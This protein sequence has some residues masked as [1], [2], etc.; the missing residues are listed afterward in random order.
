M[1]E[2]ENNL[3]LHEGSENLLCRLFLTTYMGKVLTWLAEFEPKCIY[4]QGQF[5]QM[6]VDKFK[7]NCLIKKIMQTGFL[8]KA[9][10]GET[11]IQ[12]LQRFIAEVVEIPNVSDESC[13]QHC[14]TS[15]Q[16]TEHDFLNYL[17]HYECFHIVDSNESQ[18]ILNF[19]TSGGVQSREK[20]RKQLGTL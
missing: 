14:M 7:H 12:I 8:L 13:V 18:Q 10:K 19:E 5:N 4:S 11:L 6:L 2:F 15:S 16:R 20:E 17:I 1:W 9:N 3:L